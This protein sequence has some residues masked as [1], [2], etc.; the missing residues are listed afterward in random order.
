MKVIQTLRIFPQ[1]ALENIGD[2]EQ[3]M[4]AEVEKIKINSLNILD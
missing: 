1:A 2:Q 3:M 4:L